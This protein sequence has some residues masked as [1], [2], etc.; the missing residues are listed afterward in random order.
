MGI[1]IA[2]SFVGV[3]AIVAAIMLATGSG[4]DTDAKQVIAT[5]DSALATETAES[6][7]AIVDLRKN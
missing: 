3:F 5:L 1:I 6:R 7:E 2:L 4:A